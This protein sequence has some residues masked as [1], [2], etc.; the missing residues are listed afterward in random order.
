MQR[1]ELAVVRHCYSLKNSRDRNLPLSRP[2]LYASDCPRRLLQQDDKLI[3]FEL[4]SKDAW[5]LA[6]TGVPGEPVGLQHVVRA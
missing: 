4:G 5:K 1:Y 6:R 3:D 2:A